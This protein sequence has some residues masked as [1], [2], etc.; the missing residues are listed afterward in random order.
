[1]NSPDESPK[2]LDAAVEHVPA[3]ADAGA[4]APQEQEKNGETPAMA[5]GGIPEEVPNT[6]EA[7]LREEADQN[8]LA[9]AG[10]PEDR[11]SSEAAGVSE[12]SRV[13]AGEAEEAGTLALGP[14]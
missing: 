7:P 8:P 6:Q 13:S 2:E 10:G 4:P 9:S 5:D 14:A 12:T 1:M 3:A 11:A